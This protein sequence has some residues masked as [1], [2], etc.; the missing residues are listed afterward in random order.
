MATQTRSHY[1][2]RWAL[3]LF[4]GLSWLSIGCSPQS[5]SMLLMPFADN[6]VDPEYKLFASG[7]KEITLVVMA[8]FKKSFKESQLTPDLLQ[9][10]ADLAK[11]VSRALR[12]RCEAN[13]HKL[14]LIP[15][16]QVLASQRAQEAKSFEQSED[17]ESG[18]VEVGRK[19]KADYVLHL[20]IDTLR[21]YEPRSRPK[22]FH[23]VT[24][25]S[26]NLYKVKTKNP[27]DENLVHATQYLSE[28]PKDPVSAEGGSEAQ[29]RRLFFE[30]AAQEISRMFI[31]YPPEEKR[32]HD[33]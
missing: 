20:E 16:A 7:D 12:K 32:Q 1:G 15:E 31:A 9:A 6:K 30:K 5:L 11:C 23:A 24:Q 22:M 3:V 19:L 29:F 13:K 10:D 8:N 18:P 26:V 21:I 4:G 2:W 33:D 28:Y 17:S 27:D 25:I 14:K